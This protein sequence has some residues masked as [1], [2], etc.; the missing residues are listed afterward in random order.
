MLNSMNIAIPISLGQLLWILVGL[1]ILPLLAAAIYGAVK[2]ISCLKA[3]AL[4]GTPLKES[5]SW[6]GVPRQVTAEYRRALREFGYLTARAFTSG[7]AGLLILWGIVAAVFL[8]SDHYFRFRERLVASAV[9]VLLLG[10]LLTLNFTLGA[11]AWSKLLRALD[12][13]AGLRHSIAPPRFVSSNRFSTLLNDGARWR[14][15]LYALISAPL[16]IIGWAI[17]VSLLVVGLHWLTYPFTWRTGS[18]AMMPL[19]DGTEQAVHGIIVWQQCRSFGPAIQIP[20]GLGYIIQQQSA[21]EW[22]AFDT[23]VRVAGVF[24]AGLVLL[25]V[26]PLVVR[27]LANLW[28]RLGQGL[29]GAS[30]DEVRAAQLETQRA[31]IVNNSDERLKQIERDLH[32]VTQA[33]L[34][35]IAMRTG[36]AL[37]VLSDE[38]NPDLEMKFRLVASLL[39]AAHQQAKDAMPDL[40]DIASG[41]RSPLLDNGLPIAL[42]N[43]LGRVSSPTKFPYYISFGTDVAWGDMMS[44]RYAEVSKDDGLDPAIRSLAYS[45]VSELVNNA[46]K[47]SGGTGV[48]V[49]AQRTPYPATVGA[50]PTPPPVT[51]TLTIVVKDDG[52]GGAH[53]VA[54]KDRPMAGTQSGLAGLVERLATVDGTMTI[55]SPTGGPTEI[56]VTLPTHTR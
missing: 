30:K 45:T 15:F 21:C 55:H 47:H 16:A 31:A 35:A 41:V 51:D 43:L 22:W 13:N 1:P 14:V 8:V 37:E 6:R 49:L 10:A 29:L 20:D 17:S 48:T 3:E 11:T 23:P 2:A 52:T 38:S 7:L 5:L 40:R 24:F 39:T 44:Y 56:T 46:I 53:I 19:A 33:Q 27:A 54:Q 32:D 50:S 26:W 12:Q 34:T 25:G 18:P 42:Q 9:T 4:K 36:E 28:R